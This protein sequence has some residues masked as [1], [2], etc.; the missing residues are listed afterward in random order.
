[1]IAHVVRN[2]QSKHKRKSN[3]NQVPGGIHVS[4]L[5]VRDSNSRDHSKHDHKNA[6]NDGVWNGHKQGTKFTK[7]TKNHK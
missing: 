2:S 6:T 4:I 7:D 1:M 5:Q 3:D